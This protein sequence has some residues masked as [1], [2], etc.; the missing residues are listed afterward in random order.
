MAHGLRARRNL[1][2]LRQRRRPGARPL[3]QGLRFAQPLLF[4][5]DSNRVTVK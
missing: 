4:S 5:V 2:E 3:G 1:L